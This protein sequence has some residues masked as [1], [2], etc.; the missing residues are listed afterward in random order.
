MGAIK[1]H[2]DKNNQSEEQQKLAE[3]TF[4]DI[5]DAY[6]VLSDPKKRNQFDNGM[7]PNNPDEAGMGDFG[8]FSSGGINV[9]DIFQ[10]FGGG[11]GFSG[12]GGDDMGGGFPGGFGGFPGG[13]SRGKKEVAVVANILPLNL[14]NFCY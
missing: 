4:R 2:P 3:K 10:M 7:D 8:G 6:T 1:W 9:N 13:S 11:G 12:F 5:N 14:D